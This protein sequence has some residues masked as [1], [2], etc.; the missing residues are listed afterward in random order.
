MRRGLKS[1]RQIY[2]DEIV[3]GNIHGAKSKS[4]DKGCL[5]VSTT[6]SV[7]A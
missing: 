3:C 1:L 5:E 4:L 2:R 6:A 7:K